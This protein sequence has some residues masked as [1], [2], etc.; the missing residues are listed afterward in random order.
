MFSR[1]SLRHFIQQEDGS[2]KRSNRPTDFQLRILTS[3]TVMSWKLARA[4]CKEAAKLVGLNFYEIQ[5][6]A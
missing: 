5:K 6:Q 3:I 2:E 4:T 1:T